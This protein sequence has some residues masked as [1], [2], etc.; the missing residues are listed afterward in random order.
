VAG[1]WIAGMSENGGYHTHAVVWHDGHLTRIRTHDRGLAGAVAPDGVVAVET[2]TGDAGSGLEWQW[3][4]YRNGKLRQIGP[5]QIEVT[6]MNDH[7]LAG[8]PRHAF[9]I[10]L[11][12]FRWLPAR[13]SEVT[14]INNRDEIV[15]WTT[16]KAPRIGGTFPFHAALWHR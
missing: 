9:V 6:A 14:G 10:R 1:G 12:V 8:G 3:F 2:Q 16:I 13:R 7:I 15:G 5:P 4:I 11:G